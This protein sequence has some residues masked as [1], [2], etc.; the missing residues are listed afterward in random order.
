MAPK[1]LLIH[2]GGYS[3]RMPSHSCTSKIF[4][5][6]LPQKSLKHPAIFLLELLFTLG[7]IV[8]R[9]FPVL[10]STILGASESSALPIQSSWL[11]QVQCIALVW[12]IL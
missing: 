9:K 5:D 7:T 2:S 10:F 6:Q 4:R 11:Y 3:K 1:V 12:I 8:S